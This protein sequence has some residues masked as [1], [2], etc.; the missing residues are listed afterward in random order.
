MEEEQKRSPKIDLVKTQRQLDW[1]KRKLFLDMISNNAKRRIVKRGQ[2]YWCDFGI[3]V[4]SELEKDRPAVIIQDNLPNKC[5]SNTI[6][7]PITH[8][9]SD[10][11]CMIPLKERIDEATSKPILDGNVNASH[12]VTVCKSRLGD[13]IC[14]LSEDE[15]KRIDQAVSKELDIN[16]YYL[17]LKKEYDEL[18]EKFNATTE[19]CETYKTALNSIVA[20]FELDEDVDLINFLADLKKTIDSLD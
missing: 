8:N 13:Y 10:L 2:V 3:G 11:P 18:D 17:D 4:G 7:V 20:L 6:V 14:N 19:E 5:S 16:H 1:F 15:I 9:D 12:I